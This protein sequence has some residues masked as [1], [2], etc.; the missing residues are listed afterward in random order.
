M[1]SYWRLGLDHPVTGVLKRSPCE[2]TE[3]Y[4][5]KEATWRE[6]EIR[7]VHLQT[8]G[9]CGLLAT[10]R[11]Q[12]RDMEH[13][14]PQSLEP[15]LPIPWFWALSLQNCQRRDFCC[16]KPPSLLYFLMAAP[17]NW[18]RGKSGRRKAGCLSHGM[19]APDVL[20]S[21]PSD[22]HAYSK[23]WKPLAKGQVP[24]LN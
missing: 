5:G 13:V 2:D 7:V 17:G 15:T 3:R 23:I 20:K 1:R 9:C 22:F 4:S 6:A 19:G 8:K 10:A 14:T 12:E 11:S 16:F 18:C 24:N 21:S